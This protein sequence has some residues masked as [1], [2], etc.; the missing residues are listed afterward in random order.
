M[1]PF[2]SFRHARGFT[3]VEAIIVIVITGILAGMVAIFIR[4]PVQS[5][6][7]TA[8]RADMSDAADLALRRLSRE[9][10]LAVPNSVTAQD[11]YMQFL[12]TKT[13]GR[14][15]TV[16]D[17]PP[18]TLAVLDFTATAS[19][20]FDML[21]PVP[22]GREAIVP[23]DFIVV[24]NTGTAPADAYTGGNRAQVQSINGTR[25]TLVSNPFAASGEAVQSPSL[26]FQVVA[27]TVTYVCAP[28]ANGAGRLLRHFTPAIVSGQAAAIGTGQ[29][30]TTMVSTCA[31]RTFALA[32][33][34]STLVTLTLGLQQASGERVSMMRQVLVDNTP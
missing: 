23:G 11:N 3:L 25:I 9:I 8:A 1:M 13:G 30:L 10:R 27:G 28:A 7:D 12:I 4:V 24:N 16:N 29:T 15:L 18:D 19:K 32:S 21:P 20:V 17:G 31:F 34:N 14:Y 22:T 2:R 26:R 33:Q 5:Y 6:V